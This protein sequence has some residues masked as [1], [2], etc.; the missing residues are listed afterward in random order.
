MVYL[1]IDPGVSGG[2]AVVD[3]NARVLLVTK[4]PQSAGGCVA[5]LQQVIGLGPVRAALELVHSSPQMGVKSAF[6]FGRSYGQLQMLLTAGGIHYLSPRPKA[7][8]GAMRCLT[9]GDKKVTL[10][11]ARRLFRSQ[12]VITNYTADALLLAEFCRRQFVNRSPRSSNGK[13][14]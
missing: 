14:G 2:M 6:T 13:E 1:G 9:R 7:W 10:L 8:Q 12:V 4:M 11:A 3:E 5:F